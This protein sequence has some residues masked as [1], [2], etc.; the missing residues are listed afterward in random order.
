MESMRYMSLVFRGL[1]EEY[2]NTGVRP[3]VFMDADG[4]LQVYLCDSI[5]DEM[6]EDY[7]MDMQSEYDV[8]GGQFSQA[9]IMNKA[10]ASENIRHNLE[11]EASIS[12]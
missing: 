12:Q 7:G 10:F 6:E 2:N 5:I 11:S 9:Y 1:V 8:N 4:S 3:S